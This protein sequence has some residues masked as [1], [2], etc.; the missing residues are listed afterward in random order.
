MVI[1]LVTLYVLYTI[2]L[3]IICSYR[4]ASVT[5]TVVVVLFWPIIET[6]CIIGMIWALSYNFRKNFNNKEKE[7]K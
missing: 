5:D 7:I 4:K 3:M 6:A 1:T 2:M